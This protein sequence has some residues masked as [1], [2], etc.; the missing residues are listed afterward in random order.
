MVTFFEKIKDSEKIIYP[1]S[2]R[3]IHVF[4]M[5]CRAHAYLEWRNYITPQDWEVLIDNFLVHRL[6]IDESD[7]NTLH[8]LY[9]SSFKHF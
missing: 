5:W 3:W 2:Q 9:N 6:D 1:L 4:M 8:D 7:K